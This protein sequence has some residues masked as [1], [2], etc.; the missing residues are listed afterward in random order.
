MPATTT[1]TTLPPSHDL[2]IGQV[3]APKKIVLT[4][5]RP[6]VS[7]AIK[8]TLENRG[9]GTE[10]IDPGE[11]TNLVQIDWTPLPGPNALCS[12]PATLL[13]A[14]K[15][16]FPVRLSP[17]R[18]IVLSYLITWSC[19]NDDR[20]S[21]KTEDHSDFEVEVSIDSAVLGGGGDV[22]PTDDVCPRA[23][24]SDDKGCGSKTPGGTGGAIRTD[25][26]RK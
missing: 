10:S 2:A 5:K 20:Q 12:V 3:K 13:Q 16:G 25:V 15:K 6:S 17:G 18:K 14:P 21:T 26:V 22:D 11:L 19:A 1:T 4:E 9:E 24:S 23:A 8:L 7:K